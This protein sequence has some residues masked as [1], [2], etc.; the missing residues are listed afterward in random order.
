MFCKRKIQPTC[1]FCLPIF[2]FH[3]MHSQLKTLIC[4]RYDDLDICYEEDLFIHVEKILIQMSKDRRST[5]RS[6]ASITHVEKTLERMQGQGSTPRRSASDR[7][8]YHQGVGPQ[9]THSYIW[10][11]MISSAL[12]IG[13]PQPVPDRRCRL[14][15]RTKILELE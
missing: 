4:Q 5:P 2:G 12:D 8:T 14:T 13:G 9:C 3:V 1:I 15:P 7:C 11:S 6:S 10:I